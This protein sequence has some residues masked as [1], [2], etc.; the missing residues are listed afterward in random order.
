MKK[1]LQS[2]LIFLMLMAGLQ[3]FQSCCT[4][5]KLSSVGINLKPQH[6]NCWCWAACTEMISEYYGHPVLQHESCN[7]VF[8]TH[9]TSDC[10][11]A[12][13]C[14]DNYGATINQIKN[15]WTHWGFKYKYIN[16]SLDWGDKSQFPIWE[17]KDYLR[18]TIATTSYCRKCPIYTIWWWTGGGGHVVVA[19]GYTE[20]NGVKYV[21]YMNPWPP[22]CKKDYKTDSCTNDT[23]GGNDVITTYDAFKSDAAHNWGDT[24]YDF[25]YN[26]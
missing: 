12:C 14:W 7:Y 21:S 10:P 19:Y 24:F 25:T 8:N 2:F 6:T 11:G 20:I 9:C 22:D 16:S 13:P 15:N 26:P 17:T 23:G 18:E 1:L 4:P 3:L 5:P